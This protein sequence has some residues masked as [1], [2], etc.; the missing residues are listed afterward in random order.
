MNRPIFVPLRICQHPRPLDTFIAHLPFPRNC[1]PLRDSEWSIPCLAIGGIAGSNRCP[2]PRKEIREDV[3]MLS[4][5]QS[6]R[7]ISSISVFPPVFPLN[8]RPRG[9]EI[10][11]NPF[12]FGRQVRIMRFDDRITLLLD[13]YEK[14]LIELGVYYLVTTHVSLGLQKL[15]LSSL[16]RG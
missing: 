3:S 1:K 2:D 4:M 14:W 15:I 11:W 8:D 5:H 16:V 7:F 12:Y 6:H 10:I 9:L 13:F